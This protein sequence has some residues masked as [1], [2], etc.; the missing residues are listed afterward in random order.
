MPH[1]REVIINR[2]RILL[3]TALKY[4]ELALSV[5]PFPPVLASSHKK[6]F[7]QHLPQELGCDPLLAHRLIMLPVVETLP[8]A[9]Y[10]LIQRRDSRQT[11]LAE[12]LITQFRREARKLI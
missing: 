4:R 10:Y 12:S 11:P 1:A 9:A 5:R 7:H 2:C 6:R 8:K 3:T